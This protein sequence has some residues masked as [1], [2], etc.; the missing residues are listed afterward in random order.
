MYPTMALLQQQITGTSQPEKCINKGSNNKIIEKL[1]GLIEQI[2]QSGHIAC[3]CPNWD[4]APLEGKSAFSNKN[5]SRNVIEAYVGKRRKG[6]LGNYVEVENNAE[7]NEEN[8]NKDDKPRKLV[9]KKRTAPNIRK[10]MFRV[11]RQG[12]VSSTK[13]AE[14]HQNQAREEMTTSMYCKAKVKDHSILL[15]LDSRSSEC[16]VFANF[17]KDIDNCPKTVGGKTITSKAI[18]TEAGN[19]AIIVGNDWLNKARARIDWE[20]CELMISDGN[21][22]I[23]IPTEYC[24]PAKIGEPIKNK[25]KNKIASS[26]ES[27]DSEE[28]DDEE[29]WETEDDK[30][31]QE[32]HLINKTY[33]YQEIYDESNNFSNEYYLENQTN[34]TK[35]IENKNFNLDN[36]NE[37]QKQLM[38]N[39]LLKYKD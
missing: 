33:L 13:L 36:M 24:K 9:K 21:K 16:V 17:L 10:D 4:N 2:A 3:D 15:I 35:E 14:F 31:Y 34:N 39:L 7:V 29:E 38:K 27:S 25:N 28:T 1:T 20:E 11:L 5:P 30:E 18:V 12:R 23:K 6:N 19:Y 8:A 37:T 32:E 22:K 26:P